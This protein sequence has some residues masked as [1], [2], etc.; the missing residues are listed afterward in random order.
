[1]NNIA[2]YSLCCEPKRRHAAIEHARLKP[3]VAVI[4]TS[5][6]PWKIFRMPAGNAYNIGASTEIWN[7]ETRNPN[8]LSEAT[9]FR[10]I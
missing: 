2:Y 10:F 8:L 5:P 4:S 6:L 3:A 1:M 9:R 7:P